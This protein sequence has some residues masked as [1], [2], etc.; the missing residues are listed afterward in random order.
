MVSGRL[1]LFDKALASRGQA[2]CMAM[3]PSAGNVEEEVP[4]GRNGKNDSH[5]QSVR[6]TATA[7]GMERPITYCSR[8]VVSMSRILCPLMLRK[9]PFV[10]TNPP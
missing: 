8:L 9:R 4:C 3:T 7:I 5:Q 1:P 2:D 6:R 10:T